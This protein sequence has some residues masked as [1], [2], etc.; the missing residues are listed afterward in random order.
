MALDD[1]AI[2]ILN[3]IMQK[4]KYHGDSKHRLPLTP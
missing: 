3:L 4:T 2:E 1:S